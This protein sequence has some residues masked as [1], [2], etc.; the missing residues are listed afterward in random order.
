MKLK[1][2]VFLSSESFEQFQ[3]SNSIS[4][5]QITPVVSG[6]KF[7]TDMSNGEGITN[8]AVFVVFREN[9]AQQAK[10]AIDN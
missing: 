9:S 3:A 7:T 4:V 5:C 6:L 1:Y 10:P 2:Q 8:V